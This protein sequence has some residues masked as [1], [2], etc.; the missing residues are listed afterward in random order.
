MF[1]FVCVVGV[2]CFLE[3]VFIEHFVLFAVISPSSI[4]CQGLI[5]HMH[6]LLL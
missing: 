6:P 5:C 1:G 4:C 3:F 2:V